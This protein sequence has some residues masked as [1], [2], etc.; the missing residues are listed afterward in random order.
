MTP[1]MSHTRPISFAQHLTVVDWSQ[2]NSMESSRSRTGQI[3]DSVAQSRN[4]SINASRNGT[5]MNLNTLLKREE[6]T[7]HSN[8]FRPR[9]SV[10]TNINKALMPPQQTRTTFQERFRPE[11]S[12]R[13]VQPGN[14]PLQGHILKTLDSSRYGILNKNSRNPS[15][16]KNLNPKNKSNQFDVS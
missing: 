4:V 1:P 2:T 8:E 12:S 6:T 15:H 14:M 7:T 3:A 11:N 13:L 16:S 10:S 5:G 9:V